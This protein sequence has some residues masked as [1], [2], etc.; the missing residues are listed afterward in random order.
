MKFLRIALL[1]G[2]MVAAS[3]QAG[4]VINEI[5]YDQDGTDAAEWIELHNP[6]GTEMQL[7]GHDLVLYNGTLS[8]D[9]SSYCTIDLDPYAIPAG[10]YLVFGVNDC[11]VAPL[12]VATNAI[13]NGAPDAVAIVERGTAFVV[14]S[15]EYESDM[16]NSICNFN[17]TEAADDPLEPNGSIALCEGAW[18]FTPNSTPCAENN[19]VVPD[20]EATWGAIKAIYGD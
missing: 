9:C 18:V 5:D 16:I 14:D 2:C 4:V 11:A 6:D 10:G 7:V 19:C 15:V 3:A 13:Q 17:M 12:C 1:L 8:G 20:A